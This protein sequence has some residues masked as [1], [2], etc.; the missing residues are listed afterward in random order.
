M[1]FNRNK[2]YLL[3]LGVI[4]LS[5]I[6]NVLFFIKANYDLNH[7]DRKFS[8][9]FTSIYNNIDTLGEYFLF[10]S[11]SIIDW[12][13]NTIAIT[14]KDIHNLNT[15]DL[16]TKI[17]ELSNGIFIHK[18]ARTPNNTL[19]HYLYRI[20]YD[21][22]NENNYLKNDFCS[23]FAL[24]KRIN[25]VTY[26]TDY[27]ITYNN[28]T[29]AYLDASKECLQPSQKNV[30]ICSLWLILNVFFVLSFLL[31]YYNRLLSLFIQ[32]QNKRLR[33]LMILL[34]II[35]FCLLCL[36]LSS[37]FKVYSLE[38]ISNDISYQKI[39]L[40]L[41]VSLLSIFFF[42]C[43]ACFLPKRKNNYLFD[44]LPIITILLLAVMGG[45]I[46]YFSTLKD[47]NNCPKVAS[48]ENTSQDTDKNV[49]FKLMTGLESDSIYSSLLSKKDLSA[50]ENRI[51]DYYLNLLENDYWCEVMVFSEKDSM[52]LNSINKVVPIKDYVNERLKC[53]AENCPYLQKNNNCCFVDS[54]NAFNSYIYYKQYPNCNVFV[55]CVRK[56]NNQNMNYSLFLN[57]SPH[58][59]TN[60]LA[61]P[62][63]YLWAS[64]IAI[65]FLLISIYSALQSILLFFT[66]YQHNSLTLRNKLL[67]CLLLPFTIGS[68]VFATI[69]I[70][71]MLSQNKEY[72]LN[73]LKEK[74]ISVEYQLNDILTTTD[75]I[76]DWDLAKISNDYLVDINLYDHNGQLVNKS[77]QDVYTQNIL[78]DKINKNALKTLNAPL[79]TLLIQKES[80]DNYHFL[81]SYLSLVNKNDNTKKYYV[82]IPFIYQQQQMNKNIGDFVNNLCFMLMIFINIAICLCV[83]LRNILIKPLAIVKQKLKTLTLNAQNEKIL[84]KE[85]DELG[86]LITAYNNMVDKLEQS[87]LLLKQQERNIAWRNVASQVAHDIKNPL[88]PMKLSLQY[89]IKLSQTNNALFAA[90]FSEIAPSLISQIDT[91]SN[92]AQELNLY[93]KPVHKKEIV[94][95]NDCLLAAI[96]TFKEQPNL[97]IDYT[98]TKDLLVI[99]DKSLFVRVF[100]NLIKNSSQAL[101]NKSDGKIE[102]WTEKRD[103]DYVICFKDNGI[104]IKKENFDKVFAEHFTTKQDGGGIGLTIVKTILEMYDSTI[105]FKSKENVGTI[106]FLNF[107]RLPSP[108]PPTN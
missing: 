4:V 16:Q 42:N 97:S 88:T 47:M 75:T 19:K 98:P 73:I 100:N 64:W 30:F 99:G 61:T 65:L 93:S 92:I 33:Y 41:S 28:Q 13:D 2:K 58:K 52:L 102:I 20:K 32:R 101:Y 17:V 29:I 53:S 50:I 15:T 21:Y 74:S 70:N 86:D 39:L 46:L 90:K 10:A 60:T 76:T 107:H 56:Y 83:L 69:T 82:N 37:Y 72:N 55:E 26:P 81:A 44:Y 25:I 9:Q 66:N 103:E 105:S 31:S 106:F 87:T 12:S 24:D 8:K 51:A 78:L 89:L 6:G 80:I 45:S 23:P 77:Q 43:F 22:N 34:L 5:I 7:F 27:P 18:S 94:D 36:A 96:N 71:M 95:L 14:P 3:L 40:L 84:Y 85:N 57:N 54:S 59:C 49:F 79:D 91:I 63:I 1:I 68:I 48:T 108:P 104:G 38:I 67:L 11:D 62:N 35:V